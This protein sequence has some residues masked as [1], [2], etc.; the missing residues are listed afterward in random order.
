MDA[1]TS[2]Q[3]VCVVDAQV[4]V[5]ERSAWGTGPAPGGHRA[6]PLLP[7]ELVAEMDQA[8]VSRAVLIPPTWEA[9][10]D[11]SLAAA[12]AHPGRFG[13]MGRLPLAE[14][15]SRAALQGWRG[16]PHMLGLRANFNRREDRALLHDGTADWL[17]PVAERYQIP[18]MI[19]APRDL[20]LIGMI[21][22]RHPD[23]A[24][25]ID[26]MAIAGQTVGDAAFVHVPELLTLAE[27]PGIGV[28][29]SGLP[30]AAP[31]PY[32]YTSVHGHVRRVF[33]TFGPQRLF[34]ASDLT[35]LPCSY[36]E[37]VTMFSEAIPWL[38]C[39]DMAWI[40]GKSIMNWLC[41]PRAALTADA[42]E[43]R[44]RQHRE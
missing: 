36:R 44:P 19:H 8:G 20:Q 40:M 18:I 27:H 35:R 31:D 16:T 14:P 24:I 7:D 15:K 41:W 37:A 17:W 30:S 21:A 42:P 5:W 4:H 34:W 9:R 39:C 10:N 28:K 25:V 26:H 1:L 11:L 22:S 12:T 13:V 33:D 29:L 32:P 3:R 2:T 6:A 43:S 23:L 38:S